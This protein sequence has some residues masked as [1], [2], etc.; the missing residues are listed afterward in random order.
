MTKQEFIKKLNKKL[1]GLTRVEVKERLAF[2]SEMIDDRIEEGLSEGEAVSAVGDIDRIAMQIKNEGNLDTGSEREKKK[3]LTA[4][5]TVLVIFASPIWI[6]LL[7]AALA[8]MASVYAVIWSVIIAAWAIELPFFIFSYIAKYL[9]IFCKKSTECIAL[10]TK[11]T[12]L[13]FFKFIS[14]GKREQ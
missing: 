5:E 12:F 2:Y 14:G 13:G 7:L 11:N 3:R 4:G 9:L 8:V 6:P 10:F 1:S